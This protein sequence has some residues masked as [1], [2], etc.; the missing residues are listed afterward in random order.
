M[1][2]NTS[3]KT[4]S[5]KKPSFFKGLKKE[6]RKVTWPDK[7]DI[8]KETIAVVVVTVLLG[9]AITFLDTAFKTGVLF[10]TNF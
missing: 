4:N 3:E 2:D 8:K 5:K 7:E 6:F 9:V 1:A 10:L